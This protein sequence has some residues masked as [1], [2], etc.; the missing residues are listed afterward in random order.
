MVE[1]GAAV[2]RKFLSFRKVHKEVE[3]L[4]YQRGE[5]IIRTI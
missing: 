2:E 5:K 4:Y 3:V 1:Q